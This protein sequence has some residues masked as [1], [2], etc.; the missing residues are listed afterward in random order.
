[1]ADDLWGPR[2]GPIGTWVSGGDG[3]DVSFP[4]DQGKV[5]ETLY[6]ER[7]IF[8]NLGPVDDGDQCLLGLDCRTSAYRGGEEKPFNSEFG[9]GLWDAANKRVTRGFVIQRAQALIAGATVETDATS[10]T[11]ASTTVSNTYRVL[12]NRHLDEIAHTTRFDFTITLHDDTFAYD[13]TTVI[14]HHKY[15]TVIMHTDRTTLQLVSR[16]G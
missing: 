3:R 10:S 5:A 7:T 8:K 1:M 6:R 14:E 15:P 12:S 13:E 4:N 2:Q 9:C 16:D 11:L